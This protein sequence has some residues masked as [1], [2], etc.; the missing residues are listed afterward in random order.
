MTYLAQSVQLL[1]RVWLWSHG[2]QHA[3]PPCPSPTPGVHPNP[4]PLSR[5]CHP[6]TLISVFP[7]SSCLQSFPA[8]GSFPMSQFLASGGQSFGVSSFSV[9]PSNKYSGLI[10]FRFDWFD[11]AVQ[12]IL[13]SILKHHMVHWRWEWQ[14]SSVF[15][16]WEPH[17]QHENAKRYDTERWT[18][19]LSRCPI[20]YCRRAEKLLQKEWRGW[21]KVKTMPSC[22]FDWWWK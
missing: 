17:E 21:A 18:P 16:P 19:Q 2:L 13:K 1:S 22:G 20:Y 11:L 15:L 9:S 14:T 12:G 3:R 7:F 10:S 5:W 6:T 4:C 8:S